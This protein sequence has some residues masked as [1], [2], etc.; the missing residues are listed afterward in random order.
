MKY[1]FYLLFILLL[2]Q[3][4]SKD[5]DLSKYPIPLSKLGKFKID[6]PEPSDLALTFEEDALWTVSDQNSTIYKLS[7]DGKVIEKIV[8][9]F[10]DLEGITVL[11]TNILAVAVEEERKICIINKNGELL[12]EIKLH[13]KGEYN[14]GLEGIVF[15]P[16]NKHFYAVNEKFPAMLIEL[17]KEF[18]VINEKKI[19]FVSDLSAITYDKKEK[20]LLLLSDESGLVAVCDLKGNLLKKYKFSIQQAEGICIKDGNIF[21]VSD[22]RAEVHKLGI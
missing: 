2:L 5:T 9:K 8:T 13:L 19:D 11:D 15:N 4:C 18:N 14:K 12:K 7:F 6:V 17:D 10:D 22:P 3:S 21:I 16:D 1:T 20:Q